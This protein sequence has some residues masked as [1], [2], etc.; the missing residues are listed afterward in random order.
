MFKVLEKPNKV[1]RNQDESR[2]NSRTNK[3]KNDITVGEIVCKKCEF[4]CENYYMY[5]EHKKIH[6]KVRCQFC[7]KPMASNSNLRR[8][9][10]TQHSNNAE[11]V[12]CEIC[13]KLLKQDYL[14]LH[15]KRVHSETR[16]VNCDICKKTFK[17]KD[18]LKTHTI[19]VHIDC[20]VSCHLCDKKFK[21]KYRLKTHIDEVHSQSQNLCSICGKSFKAIDTHIKLV[22]GQ[23][24]V[25]KCDIC[26][27]SYNGFEKLKA[28]KK[29]MHDPISK[30]Y[31]CEVCGASFKF[32]EILKTHSVMHSNERKYKCNICDKTFK[33]PNVLRTHLRTHNNIKPYSCDKCG[34]TY[35]WKQTY[36][37]HLIK[38]SK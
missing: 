11:Y 1:R 4:V 15:F 3:N 17:S 18:L 28:H 32:K 16:S 38:C 5:Q 24:T 7:E 37:K 14:L 12:T 33:L 30:D 2:I 20:K 26:G 34:E 8:H 21:N 6:V 13:N 29:R 9:M 31:V 23:H 25:V 27:R 35:K 10:R 19:L 22:H 36:D